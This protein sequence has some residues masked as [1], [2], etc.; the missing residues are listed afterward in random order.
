MLAT[1]LPCILPLLS[2][3]I[4]ANEKSRKGEGEG[5]VVGGSIQCCHLDWT[6]APALPREVTREGAFDYVLASDCVYWPS[7]FQP[8]VNTLT[9]VAALGATPPPVF[10]MI[11]AR[12]PSELE[13]LNALETAGFSYGKLDELHGE[14]LK[15]LVSGASAVFW[16][17]KRSTENC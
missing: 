14:S 16:A 9:A 17:M 8:L 11:E 13:F 12:T 10:F 7:L 5:T 15:P 6:S 4:L 3:N 2:R 1:D